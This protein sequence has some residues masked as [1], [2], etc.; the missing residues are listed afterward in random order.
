MKR[1]YIYFF[2]LIFLFFVN[3]V[4]VSAEEEEVSSQGGT[5][6][7]DY[8]SGVQFTNKDGI[9]S[10][11]FNAP[12]NANI[13]CEKRGYD[14]TKDECPKYV[15]VSAMCPQGTCSCSINFNE[16]GGN[17]YIKLKTKT[18]GCNFKLSSG[19]IITITKTDSKWKATASDKLS[20]SLDDAIQEKTSC[21]EKLHIMQSGYGS[22]KTYVVTLK[23]SSNNEVSQDDGK[24]ENPDYDDIIDIDG[25]GNS[26]QYDDVCALIEG[27]TLKQIQNIVG[28]VQMGTVFLILVL[29]MLDFT[30]AIG[31]SED[32][33]FKKAGSKFLKRLIAGALVFL[34]PAILGI[35]LNLV[36]ISN[37]CGI[38][39][40]SN[41]QTENE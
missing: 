15:R 40:F 39:I 13:T 41:E 17:N 26:E 4:S 23:G 8:G 25:N 31:S 21:P 37:D 24:E 38:D 3:F 29:G 1:N 12:N 27:E 2:L 16:N 22:G 33:A 28:Y 9:I 20:V 34:V 11:K 35:I 18:K 5:T 36:S 10:G 30:G 7:C 14:Y 32:N 19:T 6:L